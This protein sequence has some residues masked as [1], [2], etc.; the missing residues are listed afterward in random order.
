VCAR[1]DSAGAVETHLARIGG[2][3]AAYL[4]TFR[5]EGRTLIYTMGFRAGLERLSLGNLLFA[6][7]INTGLQRGWKVDLGN[8]TS[9]FKRRFADAVHPLHDL[10]VL[11]HAIAPV[12]RAAVAAERRLRTQPAA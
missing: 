5:A 1:L 3:L 6:R 4:V 12:V 2:K 10:F 8:G 11:P 7:A 9:F